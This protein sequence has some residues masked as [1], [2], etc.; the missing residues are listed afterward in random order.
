MR[1][2]AAIR[3][4][5]L[6]PPLSGLPPEIKRIF[7]VPVSA[8]VSNPVTEGRVAEGI[9]CANFFRHPDKQNRPSADWAK[10]LFHQLRGQDLNLRPSGYEPDELPGCSTPR[11]LLY[12][13]TL[14][15]QSATLLLRKMKPT[16]ILKPALHD[17]DPSIIN[18][19]HSL[20]KAFLCFIRERPAWPA[21]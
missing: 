3:P 8:R 18:A 14:S 11:Q 4:K 9:R 20:P 12:N 1:H 10:G 15:E 21:R 7:I 17:Y 6:V 5:D 13:I 16:I 2:N 19:N